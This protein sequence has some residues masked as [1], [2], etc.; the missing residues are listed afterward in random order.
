MKERITIEDLRKWKACDPGLSW[1][2]RNFPDGTTLSKLESAL[3]EYP[4][5]YMGWLEWLA[6]SMPTNI[7]G[8]GVYR[9]LG[10]CR[11]DYSRAKLAWFM[12]VGLA[13]DSIDRRLEWCA[14]RFD[15]A[16]LALYM[17]VGL[18]GDSIERR[19]EWCLNAVGRADVRRK[20]AGLLPEYV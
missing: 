4:I 8:D 18:D 6:W 11:T 13:G 10:W 9:R 1:F 16:C 19:A 12:P 3:Q 7:T 20:F 2:A 15:R 14:T 17:P 5:H